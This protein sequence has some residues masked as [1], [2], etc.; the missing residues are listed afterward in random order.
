[1]ANVA[2]VKVWPCLSCQKWDP[3]VR[4]TFRQKQQRMLPDIK[5]H[6][7]ALTHSLNTHLQSPW[8][9][10]CDLPTHS[11]SLSRGNSHCGKRGGSDDVSLSLWIWG[12][13]WGHSTKRKT[14]LVYWPP[15]D[16]GQKHRGTGY[17]KN[18]T[19]N[20]SVIYCSFYGEMQGGQEKKC[21]EENDESWWERTG[22]DC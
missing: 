20:H 15:H 2:W 8:H 1:M 16:L 3:C 19:Q 12:W 22:T 4:C 17:K 9:G 14:G 7:P 5:P 11:Q 21:K 6:C 13:R 10:L 18:R